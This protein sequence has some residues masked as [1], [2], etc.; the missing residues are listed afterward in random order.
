M[1]T[2]WKLHYPNL[3][4]GLFI[5]IALTAAIYG[6]ADLRG[7]S[8]VGMVLVID[9][10]ALVGYWVARTQRSADLNRFS[11]AVLRLLAEQTRARTDVEA[12]FD[13]D[14]TEPF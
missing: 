2:K 10:L 7:A 5:G 13:D 1:D 3:T 9:G 4:G 8:A 12:A 14:D 6:L 11:A